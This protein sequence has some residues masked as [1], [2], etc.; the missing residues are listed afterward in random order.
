MSTQIS[1]HDNYALAYVRQS[2]RALLGVL[3]LVG[4]IL[5]LHNSASSFRIINVPQASVF[6]GISS[7]AHH[8]R[9]SMTP[10]PLPF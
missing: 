5:S 8:Y 4:D 6:F 10:S 7:P 1:F 9:T 2:C 3:P